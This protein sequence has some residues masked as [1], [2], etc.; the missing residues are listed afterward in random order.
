MIALS[1]LLLG[2]RLSQLTS[3]RSLRQAAISLTLKMIAVPLVIGYSLRFFGVTG[4]P[5]LVLV[6][7][8]AMPPAFATLVIAEAYDLDRD[9]SV[10]TLAIGSVL[11]LLTLPLWLWLFQG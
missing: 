7:Q 6:L 5:L 4:V 10:T 2:M 3:W 1:L 11:I 8:S 9:L